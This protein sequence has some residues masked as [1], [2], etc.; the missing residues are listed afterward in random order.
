M[1][2]A[3]QAAVAAGKPPVPAAGSKADP[4]SVADEL[5]GR[6]PSEQW[7]E[8][9][10]K[11]NASL[12][13][14]NRQL[15][16]QVVAA[17]K[18]AERKVERARRENSKLHSKNEK[19]RQLAEQARRLAESK[20]AVLALEKQDDDILEALE[21]ET[22]NVRRKVNAIIRRPMRVR[23]GD[24]LNSTGTLTPGNSTHVSTPRHSTGHVAPAKQ[25]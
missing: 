3:T 20:R 11:E 10:S 4:A 12:R 15:Q 21:T 5:E 13:A 16:E 7:Y 24:P 25:A 14:E 22:E 19:L 1:A 8:E 9:L 23:P 18:L 17:R 6:V 2:G